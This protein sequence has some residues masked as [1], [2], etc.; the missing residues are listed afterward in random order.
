MPEIFV[1]QRTLVGLAGDP[2]WEASPS[3]EKR[4]QRPPEK[5]AW[6]HFCVV[7]VL[8]WGAASTPA[9]LGLSKTQ[10][11]ELLCCPN[12]KEEGLPLSL[13]VFPPRE[14]SNLC[15]PEN[16]GRGGR[17]PQVGGS[18]QWGGMGSGPCLKEAS[19]PHFCR[20]S[21]LCW[22]IAFTLVGLG[23][24]DPPGWNSWV[25]QTTKMVTNFFYFC[26]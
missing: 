23:F 25:V 11:L 17:R 14:F 5:A 7:A 12:S 6:S 19:W 21:V 16:N 26:K 10:R 24:P 18:A 3:D 22:G 20:A 2:G 8:C 15:R 13:W 4:G 1:S 9:Q